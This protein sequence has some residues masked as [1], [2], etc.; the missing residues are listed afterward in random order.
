MR[1]FKN[2]FTN[3]WSLLFWLILIL[4][5][6]FSATAQQI[7]WTQFRG[8][9]LDGT[10]KE[11]GIPT[12][13]NDSV[14]VA[15]KT[16]IIG[17]GW[18]SPVVYGNQVWLSTAAEDGKQMFGVC[19][20]LKT[21]K[22]ILNIK[23]FEPETLSGKHEINTYASP[24][25]CI[26]LGLVYFHFGSYG[27]ACLRTND[28]S[29]VWKRTDLKCNHASGPGS[30][31]I[32][33]KNLLILHFDG[34]DKQYLVALD[35]ETGKTVWLKDR[36]KDC[37]D[38]LEPIGK[39]AY[40][41]PLVINVN[42]KDLLISNGSAVCIA[43]NPETGEEVWRVVEG[44]DSTIAMPFFEDGILFFY[45]SFVTSADGEKY[46]DLLAVNPNGS[47]NITTKNV[48]WR[49][50]SPIMQLL[51]PLIK[52]GLIYTVDTMNNLFC[53]DAK[54]G[55]PVYTKRLTS[56]YNA[57]PVYAGGNIYFTS[58]KG[59][60]LVIKEGKKL[61][62]VSR[63]KLKGEVFATPA[64]SDKSIIIRAGTSLYCI[65]NK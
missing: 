25:P 6:Q 38:K 2:Q 8:S 46:I 14:N 33:Y 7:N 53:I 50:R 28:G 40:M 35:K 27:T 42:R 65:R 59:E 3:S 10:S 29:V 39:K 37:Y 9:S 22:E 57:S 12:Y 56:K 13:W 34:T 62:I 60:T 43:Y 21:G 47:G 44:E 49:L 20:D 54:T 51:T 36:P 45:S 41:T 17:K 31:P 11:T 5:Y 1:Q 4:P 26:E 55:K 61:E 63:N 52:D 48:L 32:I 23:L 64:I 19:I 18:S 16:R 30:S 15:W 24:T 58:T